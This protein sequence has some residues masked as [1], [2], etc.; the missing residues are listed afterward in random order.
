MGCS[1]CAKR[2]EKLKQKA[3]QLWSGVQKKVA[4]P[5]ARAAGVEAVVEGHG[6]DSSKQSNAG[7]DAPVEPVVE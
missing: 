4:P 5:K 7:I 1:A 2:R 3:R 6:S